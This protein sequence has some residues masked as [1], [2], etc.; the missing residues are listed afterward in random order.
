MP[1]QIYIASDHA[2]FDLKNHLVSWL[3]TSYINS[4]PTHIDEIYTID[5]GTSNNGRL[6]KFLS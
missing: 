3:K 2:G 4:L 1:L 5:M 6:V